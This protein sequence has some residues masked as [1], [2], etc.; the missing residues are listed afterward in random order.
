MAPDRTAFAAGVTGLAL[1]ASAAVV[2][3]LVTGP[4]PEDAARNAQVPFTLDRVA[5]AAVSLVGFFLGVLAIWSAV[6]AWLRE[7]LLSPPARWGAGLGV[8]GMLL[9]VAI[10]PCGP[11]G[12]PG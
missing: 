10:G 1:A 4:L 11:Q 9:V 2:R 6:K 12:C 7:D 3:P 8:A 5:L